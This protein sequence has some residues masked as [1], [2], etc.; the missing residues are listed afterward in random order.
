MLASGKA[1]ERRAVRVRIAGVVQGVGFRPFVYRLAIEN[2]ISGWVLNGE[3]GVH[4]VAEGAAGAV[5]RFV[6]ALRTQAPPAANISTFDV[7]DVEFAGFEA[8]EIHESTG[9]E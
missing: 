8:F 7:A 1:R 3:D 6:E 4:V 5:A 2:G 9:G